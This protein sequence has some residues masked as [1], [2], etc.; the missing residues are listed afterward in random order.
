MRRFF[1]AL[2]SAFFLHFIL[3]GIVRNE[4]N[5][6]RRSNAENFSSVCLVVRKKIGSQTDTAIT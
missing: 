4:S 2:F 3:N 1:S 5:L 6:Y